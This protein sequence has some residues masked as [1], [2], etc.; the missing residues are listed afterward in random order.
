MDISP[1]KQEQFMRKALELAQQAREEGEVP[2]GAI[3]V[4]KDMI[5]GKGYNQSERL[6]DATAH[7]EMI[8]I[9][10]AADYLNSKYLKDCTLFVT[11]EP[12]IMCGGAAQWSQLSQIV[13][14]ASDTSKG[15]FSTNKHLL[16]KK[17]KTT[18]GLLADEC[19]ELINSFFKEKR[20]Y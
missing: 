8:A 18:A 13:Y 17:T 9:T 5:I 19:A 2:V 12:C 6:V 14:G 7:A 10:A 11:L 15:C 4:Y 16:P 20:N 1:K 3:V